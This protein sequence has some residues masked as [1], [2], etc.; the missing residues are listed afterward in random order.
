MLFGTTSRRSEMARSDAGA[1]PTLILHGAR[2]LTMDAA[3]PDAEAVAISQGRIQAVGTN[4]AVWALA[5]PATDSVD[6]RGRL[7][8]PGFIDAHAH[9][10][11][12]AARLGFLDCSAAR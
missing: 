2:V 10:L 5:G 7:L 11:G 4:A 9:L 6:C 12:T 1:P 8:I 3:R